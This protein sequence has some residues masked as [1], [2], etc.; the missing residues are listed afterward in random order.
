MVT[1]ERPVDI[2]QHLLAA[3]DCFVTGTCNASSVYNTVSGYAKEQKYHKPC[4]WFLACL[5]LTIFQA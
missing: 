5:L 4:D 2:S 1:I 3:Q